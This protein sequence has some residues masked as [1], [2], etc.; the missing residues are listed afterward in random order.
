MGL[1]FA[2]VLLQIQFKPLSVLLL[3]AS[4][5]GY[6]QQSELSIQKNALK[7]VFQLQKT[8]TSKALH[9]QNRSIKK[10]FTAAS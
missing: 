5:T 7:A 9:S 3:P 1:M 10:L 6:S 8:N 4:V 2:E